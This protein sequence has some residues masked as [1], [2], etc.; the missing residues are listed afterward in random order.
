ML[1]QT[2][3]L[4]F[5]RYKSVHYLQS[6]HKKNF[7]LLSQSAKILPKILYRKNLKTREIALQHVFSSFF[8]P[9]KSLQQKRVVCNVPHKK[10]PEI[11]ETKSPKTTKKEE[12]EEKKCLKGQTKDCF[13]VAFN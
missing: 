9:L 6:F 5:V 8:K 7:L 1:F 12:D 13:L 2:S 11:P 4:I 3:L 10:F